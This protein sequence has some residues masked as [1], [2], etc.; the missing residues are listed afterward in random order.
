MLT[1]EFLTAVQHQA[2]DAAE[3]GSAGRH[4]AG[5]L[6]HP[7]L[8]RPVVRAI[9]ELIPG[10]IVLAR[11]PVSRL[12]Q[13][14]RPSGPRRLADLLGVIAGP[15]QVPVEQRGGDPASDQGRRGR[16]ADP[17]HPPARVIRR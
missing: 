7:Q 17:L 5:M 14:V 15:G 13:V 9:G 4:R 1:A 12:P 16:A 6:G 10:T 3:H 11:W 2:D 8:E